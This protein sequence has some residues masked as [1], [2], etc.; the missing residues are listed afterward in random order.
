[1]I[2][3]PAVSS[4]AKSPQ[5]DELL[6]PRR[7]ASRSFVSYLVFIICS[8]LYLL[9]FMRIMLQATDE[10][11][12]IEG[13]VRV[14]HGQVF[15]RDFL[16]TMGPGTFY[17]LAAFFKSFGV[18]FVA[19]R[20]CLFVT[21]LGTGILVYFL[22]HRVCARYQTLPCILLVGTSFGGL[23]PTISHHVDS[24]FC[25]LGAVACILLW[26]EKR[27]S[28][29]LI[30]GGML[31]AV[32]TS[33]HQP[34]GLLLLFAVVLW[35]LIWRRRDAAP[36]SALGLVLA[37]YCSIVCAIA[38]YFANRNAIRDLLYASFVWPYG[39]YGPSNVVPY[40]Q[41]LIIQYWRHLV[42]V[43]SGASWSVGLATIL[44]IPFVFVAALPILIAALGI[45][46][47][48]KMMRSEIGLYWLCGWALWLSEIHRKDI[49]HI[50]FG[51]PL[52][53]ILAVYLLMESRKKICDAA[54]QILAISAGC[55]ACFNLFL[56]VI[57][58]PVMT[59]VGSIAMFNDDPVLTFLDRHVASGEEIFAYP[60]CP[61]YYFLLATKN[62]TR[63]S[64]LVYHYNISSQFEEVVRT[65]DLHRVKYVVWD[66]GFED[67]AANIFFPAMK[68][69]DPQ[70][71]ILEPYLQS[72]YRVVK[73]VGSV[74]V[75]ERNDEVR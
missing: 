37:G 10:G 48:W 4:E 50:V 33:I 23:W 34:K 56:A 27:S 24:N 54:L 32:T 11:T 36:M 40:A 57:A 60:Y 55:L 47:G 51:S 8:V 16:E 12:L 13:A 15:A 31:A 25:A 29:L 66:T 58:H 6:E 39:H 22:S 53:I 41:G 71:H 30:A 52:L 17:W 2:V 5:T 20:I 7:N 44:I 70:A 75:M 59:R 65:L 21:S 3:Y 28:A 73:A 46:S 64:I 9:P 35:L 18:T 63:Y 74:H 43:D 61:M 38:M 19:T 67:R 69:M 62:P 26:D 72:H 45:R 1:M 68:S 49:S 14:A 42:P